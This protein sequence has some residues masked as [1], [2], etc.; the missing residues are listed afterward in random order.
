M[1]THAYLSMFCTY[2]SIF[3]ASF[4]TILCLFFTFPFSPQLQLSQ[5]LPSICTFLFSLRF[6]LRRNTYNKHVCPYSLYLN[7]AFIRFN[8]KKF[9]RVTFSMLVLSLKALPVFLS[10]SGFPCNLSPRTLIRE[11]KTNKKRVLL[12]CQPTA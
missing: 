10:G 6:P 5:F 2:V 7:Q 3:T 11:E 8:L 1:T 4:R 12:P 9:M